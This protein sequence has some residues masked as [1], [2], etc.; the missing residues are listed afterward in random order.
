[1]GGWLGINGEA[2]YETRPWSY[3]NDS[4]S[5]DLQVWYTV[6]KDGSLVYG[7]AL[8][9][10][11]NADSTI[12]LGDI[13]PTKDTEIFLIGYDKGSLTY[14]T[15]EDPFMGDVVVIEFPPMHEFVHLCGKHC[16]WGYVLKMT[17]VQP[18]P[19]DNEAEIDIEIIY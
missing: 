8:G 9:W 1:M 15:I 17:N 7:T 6:S 4:L 14:Q 5:S 10:P 2:I 13:K 11:T 19:N 12:A 18:R 3:Q 16:Q